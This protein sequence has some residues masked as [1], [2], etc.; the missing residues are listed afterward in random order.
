MSS[1][2]QP[3]PDHSSWGINLRTS[4]LPIAYLLLKRKKDF[5]GARPIISYIHFLYATLFRATAITLDVI[6]RATCPRSF[7]LNTL[8]SIL[9]QLAHFL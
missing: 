3:A 1:Y 7:G 2:V 9:Q 5:N 6:M 8:P 4:S